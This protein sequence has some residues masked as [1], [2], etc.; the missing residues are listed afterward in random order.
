M[1]LDN[2]AYHNIQVDRCPTM[3]IRKADMEAWLDRHNVT[4][5]PG[6]LKTE[7]LLLCKQNAKKVYV[8]Q[9]LTPGSEV[10]S[11]LCRVQPD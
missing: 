7:V 4:H 3:A 6:T 9:A 10:F 1:V 11:L 2:A 8:G 5:R